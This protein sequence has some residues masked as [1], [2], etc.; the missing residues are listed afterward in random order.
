MHSTLLPRVTRT[1][2]RAATL[3]GVAA[4]FTSLGGCGRGDR[5]ADVATASAAADR[6]AAPGP[7]LPAPDTSASVTN[8]STLVPRPP[9]T[10]PTAPAG[11]R[12]ARYAG[13]LDNP[14]WLHVL[15][16][17]DVLVA[18][19]RTEPRPRNDANMVE[20]LRRSG[21][22]GRS[23]DRVTLLRDA[24]RDG[25]PEVRAVMLTARE[26]LNQ[27]FGIAYV[28]G[29]LYVA[30]T[31][32][33]LRFPYR[34]GDTRIA[35][36]GARVL[37]LPAG[38]YNNHW[39]RNVVAS[40][41]G[42]KLY[43]TVGSGSN[44]AENGI[45]NER[46]RAGVLEVNPDGSGERVFASGLRNPNGLAWNPATGALWAAVNERDGL[47]DDL[48]PDYITSVRDG[49]FYG[50][51]YSY[52]GQNEDPRLRGQRPDLV[53][54]AVVPDVPVGAHTA[55]LGLVFYADSGPS[56]FPA[57]YRGGAFVGQHGSW[58]RSRPSG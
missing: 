28:D 53:R 47:G 12:V 22:V 19:S 7:V 30:N 1:A 51:P 11:F 13:A 3:G 21:Q 42:A 39:T 10:L 9:G 41:D 8:F 33:L 57:R 54:Q 15:P 5:R 55:S 32:A 4:A 37:A 31:D 16:N 38:G 29:A 34:A 56:A 20:G 49:A 14:R 50:W 18:E 45:D 24:D 23:A 40:R 52:F 48:V 27:P 25:V 6:P 35:V 17:G 58:N 43:V 26:G 46:R 2:A 36:R 44:V